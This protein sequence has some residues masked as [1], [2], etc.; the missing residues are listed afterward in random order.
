MS[1]YIRQALRHASWNT[2]T[3]LPRSKLIGLLVVLAMP[4]GLAVPLCY[5][6]YV[7]VRRSLTR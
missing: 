2:I 3:S 6:V 1:L 4:G 7:A 5:A